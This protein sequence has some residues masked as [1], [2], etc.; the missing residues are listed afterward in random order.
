MIF[1]NIV[2]PFLPFSNHSSSPFQPILNFNLIIK[3]KP[4][5]KQIYF[6]SVFILPLFV[7]S[8]QHLNCSPNAET[9]QTQKESN[10]NP[11]A[12]FKITHTKRPPFQVPTLRTVSVSIWRDMKWNSL[13]PFQNERE[14][15]WKKRFR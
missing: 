14:K 3:K 1:S 12:G 10:A 4:K 13:E 2:K 6:D 15:Y 7:F 9:L 5:R 11:P 8:I